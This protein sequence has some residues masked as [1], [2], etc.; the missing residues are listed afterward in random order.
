[1]AF[2]YNTNGLG[3]TQRYGTQ[4]VNETYGGVQSSKGNIKTAEWVVVLQDVISGAPSTT[5]TLIEASGSKL[6]HSIPAYSKILSCRAVFETAISTT[7]GTAAASAN[8]SVG[9]EQAD[10]T[11]IDL[12][13]LIDA[14]DGA[15]TISANDIVGVKGS[16]LQ[17]GSAALVP[18]YGSA[19][20]PAETVSIGANAGELYVLLTINDVT[21][22]TAATGKIR[23]IVEYLIPSA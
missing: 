7:G 20:T 18:D 13:G 19:A 1:M 10:G 3:N 16:Y 12:D 2:E 6:E 8:L 9:L 4:K 15:L 23:I 17:G 11:D 21:A 5:N 22:M 14:T